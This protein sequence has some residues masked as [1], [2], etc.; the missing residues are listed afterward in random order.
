MNADNHASASTF[1]EQ[2]N[3]L[4]SPTHNQNH[5]SRMTPNTQTTQDTSLNVSLLVGNRANR[6]SNMQPLIGAGNQ[7]G[8]SNLQVS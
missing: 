6:S 8:S 4:S 5:N 1:L 7:S 3:Q 2:L